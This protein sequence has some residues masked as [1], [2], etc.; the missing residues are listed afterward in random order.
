MIEQVL[1]ILMNLMWVLVFNFYF[2]L[3]K[4]LKI[5]KSIRNTNLKEKN[6]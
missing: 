5:I 2:F 1:L 4:T 6:I 3:K